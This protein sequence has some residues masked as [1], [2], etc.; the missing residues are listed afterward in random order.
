[1]TILYEVSWGS[2]FND[3][4]QAID[5]LPKKSEDKDK[6]LP[7]VTVTKYITSVDAAK[8]REKNTRKEMQEI[9]AEASDE[10]E[11]EAA[12]KSRKDTKPTVSPPS[13]V[14]ESSQVLP[15]TN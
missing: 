8:K 12:E 9:L 15:G 3:R 13:K 11:K 14:P 4:D 6:A 7:R 1:M 10:K 5:T 2:R